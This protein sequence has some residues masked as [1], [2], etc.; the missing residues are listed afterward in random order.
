MKRL[1]N[2]KLFMVT[3][4]TI[5]GEQTRVVFTKKLRAFRLAAQLKAS[6]FVNGEES[7]KIVEIKTIGPGDVPAPKIESI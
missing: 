1:K 4:G 7:D 6:Y 2:K 3:Y 5:N